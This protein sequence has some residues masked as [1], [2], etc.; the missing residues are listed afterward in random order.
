MA[1]TPDLG[2]GPVRGGGSSPL[3]R[4]ILRLNKLEEKRFGRRLRGWGVPGEEETA[5]RIKSK[6]TKP[7][8][9]VEGWLKSPLIRPAT[10]CGLNHFCLIKVMDR[11]KTLQSHGKRLLHPEDWIPKPGEKLKTLF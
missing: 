9:A 3:A 4:T 5:T 7:N 11:A 8:R 10:L 6:R 1:D 2:S